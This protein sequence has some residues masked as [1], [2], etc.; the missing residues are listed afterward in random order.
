MFKIKYYLIGIIFCISGCASQKEVEWKVCKDCT[1]YLDIQTIGLFNSS[2]IIHLECVAD[3][4][5]KI[6]FTIPKGK[7]RGTVTYVEND[8][9]QHFRITDN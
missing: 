4:D 6:S 5:G 8:K 3:A 1:V 2:K 9:L 7:F